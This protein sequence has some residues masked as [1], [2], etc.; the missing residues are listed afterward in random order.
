VEVEPHSEHQEHDA[1]LGEL[2]GK[3]DVAHETGC[4]RPDRHAG[5]EVRDD[6]REAKLLRDYP[7][8]PGSRESGGHRREERRVMGHC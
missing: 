8:H 3:L 2:G 4:V 7:E 1:D 6:R 5:Q